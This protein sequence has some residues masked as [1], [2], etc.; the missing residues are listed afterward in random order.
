VD[1]VSASRLHAHAED[2]FNAMRAF[3]SHMQTTGSAYTDDF[4]QSLSDA[5]A[6]RI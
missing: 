3:I 2:V 6:R 4:E 1:F 5:E